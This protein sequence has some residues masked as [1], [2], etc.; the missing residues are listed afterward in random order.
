M[1]TTAIIFMVLSMI[2][3]WGGLLMA[4]IH[5]VKN[6]DKSMQELDL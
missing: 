3:I 2:L 1:T 5:L 4:I 6:P